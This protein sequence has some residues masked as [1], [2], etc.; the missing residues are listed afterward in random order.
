MAKYFISGSAICD[1]LSKD[2]T[3]HEIL[4]NGRIYQ[5]IYREFSSKSTANKIA[6]EILKRGEF[7][8]IDCLEMSVAGTIL[9]FKRFAQD[10]KD[11]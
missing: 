6:S 3:S 1:H 5:T 9:V 11:K 4:E 2:A 8:Q 10:L 7:E